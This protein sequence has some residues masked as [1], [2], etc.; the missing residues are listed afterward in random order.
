MIDEAL[1]FLLTQVN[2]Y[3][4][5]K[6]GE[7]NVVSL[8][9]MVG[10]NGEELQKSNRVIFQLINIDEERVG[11]HQL[12]VGHAVGGQFP[13]RN[14]AIHLNLSVMF[15]ALGDT[16]IEPGSDPDYLRSI[17][18]LGLVVRF[19]QYRHVFTVVNSPD[20]PR[21]LE[22][23]ILELYPVTLDN[24]NNLWAT[25]GVKY[26]PSVVYKVRMLTVFEDAFADLVGAPYK[27]GTNFNNEQ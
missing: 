6:L 2:E 27:L 25:L 1:G 14:P 8:Q 11:K 21:S 12:P 4:R 7:E 20:L 23:L 15:T 18:L 9:R 19:F 26:R 22:Q 13:L 24:Q 5:L 10:V 17:R 16:N 3:L